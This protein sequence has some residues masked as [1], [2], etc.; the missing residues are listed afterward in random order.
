M[1]DD[2]PPP[3]VADQVDCSDLDG[4]MLNAERLMSSELLALHGNEI[5][6]AALLLWCRAWKQRPAASLPDDDRVNAAFARL[7]LPKFRRVKEAVMRG[8]V[9]CSDG[10]LYHRFLASVA[11]NAYE[12]KLAFRKKRDSDRE[13]LKGWRRSRREMQGVAVSNGYEASDETTTE[14][15]S[16]TRFVADGNGKERERERER[17]GY[18]KDL[19]SG[20]TKGSSRKGTRLPP[21][22]KPTDHEWQEAVR[23]IGRQQAE[24]ESA[25][26]RDYWIAKPG[27]DGHKLDWDA[28]WRNWVRK[29]SERSSNKTTLALQSPEPS[30]DLG[31]EFREVPVRNLSAIVQMFAEQRIWPF[32]SPEP[33]QPGCRVPT[34]FLPA[35]LH[36]KEATA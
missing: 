30:I 23:S 12:K 25:K 28:T 17:E 14:T 18:L 27:K 5:V 10:R 31:G 22:W 36:H 9:K 33:G 16:E 35:H 8:F 3:L 20:D 13:R 24:C 1:N 34:K 26:F 29:A 19:P 4:F 32:P 6:G 7:S 21:D 15:P 2:L 11:L